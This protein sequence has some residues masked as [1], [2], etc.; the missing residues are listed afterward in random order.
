MEAS[1]G[2]IQYTHIWGHCKLLEAAQKS[3]LILILRAMKSTPTQALARPIL[4][5]KGMGATFQKKGKEMLE[6]VE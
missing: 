2:D 6:W 3:A 1:F 5:S 4:E